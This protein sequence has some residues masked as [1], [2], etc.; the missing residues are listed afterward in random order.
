MM[1]HV[2]VDFNTNRGAM[3]QRVL[4]ESRDIV[5]QH[6]IHDQ[7]AELSAKVQQVVWLGVG[8]C[9]WVGSDGDGKHDQYCGDQE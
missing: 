2:A 4:G 8:G 7:A 1:G 5:K 6:S 3:L 9:G